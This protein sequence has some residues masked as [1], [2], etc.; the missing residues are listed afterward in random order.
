MPQVFTKAKL[1]GSTNGKAIK[2]AATATAGTTVHTAVAGTAAYDELY[3]Y[4]NNTSASAV[5]YTIEYGGVTDPDCLVGKA[6]SLPPN[7]GP[8]LVIPGLLINNTLVVAVFCGT[9]NVVLA[10]GFVNQIV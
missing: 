10:S 7:S 1:S 9:A 2:I 3:L 5:T 8:I 4:L 6:V